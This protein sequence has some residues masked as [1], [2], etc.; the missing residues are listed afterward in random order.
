MP[1]EETQLFD[2]ATEVAEEQPQN[3]SI[4]EAV[5][6]GDVD[7][8]DE[9]IEADAQDAT[10]DVVPEAKAGESKE[11]EPAEE[12]AATEEQAA[13]KEP[14]WDAGLLARAQQLGMT[15]DEAKGF[16]DGEKLETV[17]TT[18]DRRVADIGR[19]ALQSQS[20]Q[21]QTVQQQPVQQVP[22]QQPQQPQQP[23]TIQQQPPSFEPFKVEL[24]SEEY[25]EE[26][27]K[28]MQGMADHNAGQMQL[29]ATQFGNAVMGLHGQF[30]KR[31]Q[32]T[33]VAKGDALIASL[34]EEYVDVFG[35]GSTQS[36]RQG[37]D[38]WNARMK[39]FN[40]MDALQVGYQLTNPNYVPSEADL[41]QRV[42]RGDFPEKV[43]GIKTSKLSQRL[44]DR[45]GQ[46]VAP[47]SARKGAPVAK[48]DEAS[49]Y[50]R[51]WFSENLPDGATED[52]L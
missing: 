18:L 6:D 25:G 36:M 51:N 11:Q 46:F 40:G 26:V 32:E 23:Q 42:L 35:K 15:E 47:T 7:F 13:A 10:T 45:K 49:A 17:L 5:F 50:V 41:K 14:E 2:E 1:D 31:E 12:P 29:L 39:F 16:G 19:A 8:N 28:A 21:P 27:T 20:Q 33:L 24:K 9:P 52:G 22:A 43:N 30:Q 3:T 34:G 4:P 38:P 44:R 48:E 37:S